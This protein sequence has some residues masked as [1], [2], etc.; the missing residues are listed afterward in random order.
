[1]SLHSG[2]RVWIPCEVKPG[3]FSDERFVRV[4]SPAGPIVL[5]VRAEYTEDPDITDGETRV[6]ALVTQV[7]PESFTARLP[8]HAVSS[9]TF[10]GDTSGVSAVPA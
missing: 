3:P 9:K 1:M 4:D 2:C 7:S 8:G 5:F 6:L 10:R